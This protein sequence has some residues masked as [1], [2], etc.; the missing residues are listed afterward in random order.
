MTTGATLGV[1]AID[2]AFNG[3]FDSVIDGTTAYFLSAVASVGVF[4]V[5]KNATVQNLDL[6]GV[7]G[8]D[9]RQ[10]WTGIAMYPA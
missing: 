1:L 4:D 9:S 8:V 6:S 10:W 2:A 7:T 3:A 5:A